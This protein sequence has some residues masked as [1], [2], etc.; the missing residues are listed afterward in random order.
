[1]GR[2]ALLGGRLAL[3]T[4]LLAMSLL[5][6]LLIG[7]NQLSPGALWD[8]ARGAGSSEANYILFGQRLPR[9]VAGVVVGICLGV[10]GCLTQAFTRN[11][12]A[13]PGILGVNAGAGVLVAVGVAFF[14]LHTP[15]HIMWLACLGALLVTLAVYGIGSRASV[16]DSPLRLLLAGVALGAALSGVTTGIVLTHPD[17]FDRLR[18]WNAGTLLERGYEVS[19]PASGMLL[20]GVVLALASA[21][22]LNS[23][24]LGSDVAKSQGVSVRRNQVLVLA[25]VTLLAGA[26]TAVAGPIAFI[27]LMVPHVARWVVGPNQVHI[28]LVTLLIAP[29]FV[30]LCDVLGRVLVLPGEMP[31]GVMVA[32]VGGPVLIALVRRKE[33]TGL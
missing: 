13:D 10:A 32:F 30:L 24:I 15:A 31:V 7:A 27:G 29:L 20:I 18:G 19:L 4:T 2:P 11:P 26:A 23:M 12:L 5:A 33:G 21:P 14:S 9:T 8:A 17:A 16:N 3:L 22:G 25:A 6:S 28:V 1:M